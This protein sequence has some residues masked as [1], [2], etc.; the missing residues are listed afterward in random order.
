MRRWLQLLFALM[1]VCVQQSALAAQDARMQVDV[2]AEQQGVEVRWLHANIQKAADMA[3]PQLW[4][5][6]VP[7]HALTQIPKKVKAVR[8]LKKAVPNEQG[9]S[10]IFNEKRVLRYLKKNA[11]PY[12]AEQTAEQSADK[13]AT[14][15]GMVQPSMNVAPGLGTLAQ[16]SLQ[17][18]G[19]LTVQR[20][21][22]LPEQVLF[23]D[24][25][26]RD[27]RIIRMTLRQINRGEQ[28][29]RLQLKGQ[30]DRW[31]SDW[32]RQRGLV[33]TQSV[34]GWVAH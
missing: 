4:G 27:P 25:L 22:S 17:R 7:Q 21:A 18:T 31:L 23:E 28:Q 13:V 3:L 24:D 8:F 5:R 26:A 30:D 14:V 15:P 1:L 6:I 20:Q 2:V 10:I 16:P 34:E 9:V 33:L 19:L 12:Y 29:Y 32:F 11:I